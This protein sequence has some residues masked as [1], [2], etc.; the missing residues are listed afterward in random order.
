MSTKERKPHHIEI[1]EDGN[2]RHL[3][4]PEKP[5]GLFEKLCNTFTHHTPRQT[6]SDPAI[7]RSTT[8]EGDDKPEPFSHRYGK[9]IKILHYGSSTFVGLYAKK[10]PRHS[11]K[12][13]LYAVKVRHRS[14][15]RLL[16]EYRRAAM[17]ISSVVQHPNVVRTIEHC[18][19][20]KGDLH[21]VMEYCGGGSLQ[22]LL[23]RTGKLSAVEADCFFKQLLRGVSFLHGEG[24]VHRRLRAE[25]VLLTVNGA[26]K[27]AHFDSAEWLP[28]DSR[29]LPKAQPPL[30]QVPYTAPEV[31]RGHEHDPRATDVWAVG[32]IYAFMRLGMLLWKVASDEDRNFQWYL[33]TREDVEGFTTIEEFGSDRCCNV[34]YAMLDPK[35]ERRITAYEALHSEWIHEVVLCAVGE[36]GE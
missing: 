31:L 15:G 13:K 29:P 22:T 18:Y 11:G 14:P 7:S 4:E 27:V 26:V 10:T 2:H 23:L 24:I 36:A 6:P 5:A 9:C 35:P 30:E 25:N 12:E 32:L 16:D 17:A 34:I 28:K 20:E 19:N 21:S 33:R 3:I 1:L 8:S